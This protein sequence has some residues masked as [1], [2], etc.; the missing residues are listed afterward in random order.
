MPRRFA[1]SL[2]LAGVLLFAVLMGAWAAST[3]APKPAAKAAVSAAESANKTASGDKA[4]S[5]SPAASEKTPSVKAPADKAKAKSSKAAVEPA[6]NS[7]CMVCHA[8]FN[9]EKL[10]KQHEKVGIGCEKCHGESVKHSG[11]EDGL[12]PPEKMFAKSEI[13][14]FCIKCHPINELRTKA[15]HKEWQKEATREDTC[16]DCHATDHHIKV[17]TRHWDKK[18]GKL[19]KDDGVRMMQKDSP[20]TSGTSKKPAAK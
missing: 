14:G 10:M 18:T 4:S 12:T 19:L 13:N 6:D 7:Y 15:I 17:R 3:D 5:P 2:S 8:N 16:S 1:A 11:D 20:A 9:A